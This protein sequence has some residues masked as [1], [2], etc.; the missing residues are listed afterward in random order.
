ML[1]IYRGMRICGCAGAGLY[2]KLGIYMQPGMRMQSQDTQDANGGPA[3][4]A[5]RQCGKRGSRNPRHRAGRINKKGPLE[6]FAQGARESSG[7]L[8]SRARGPG[9]IG[10]LRLNFRVRDG[11]G[12]DPHSITAETNSCMEPN[13]SLQ[14]PEP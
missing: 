10:D 7:D 3:T 9:T 5:G 11:N 13:L 8:L 6:R 1:E 4:S 14:S 2:M 12:C